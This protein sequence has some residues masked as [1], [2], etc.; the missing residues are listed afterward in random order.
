MQ[1]KNKCVVD[2]WHTDV[3]CD[4]MAPWEN[5]HTCDISQRTLNIIMQGFTLV[6]EL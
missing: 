3:S 1:L 2:V 6:I 4:I 5:V